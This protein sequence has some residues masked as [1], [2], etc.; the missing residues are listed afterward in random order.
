MLVDFRWAATPHRVLPQDLL[1]LLNRYSE[2]VGDTVRKEGGVPIQFSGD[3][4]TAV[5]GLDVG[6]KEA[7]RQALTA[8][9]QVDAA[10]AAP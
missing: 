9:T 5:F 1:Y 10:L 7:N 8:A 6:A 3:G 2:I 4:V